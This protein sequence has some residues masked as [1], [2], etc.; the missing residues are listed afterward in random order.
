LTVATTGRR[1]SWEIRPWPS[2]PRTS[3]TAIS[4]GLRDPAGA[5]QAHP[6]DLRQVCGQGIRHRGTEDHAGPRPN[7][8]EIGNT[9]HLERIKVIDESGRMN[10]LAGP[11]QGMD[12]FECRERILEDLKEA[13]LL[14]KSSP[15]AM[16]SATAIGARP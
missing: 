3:G 6:G 13:G 8:F 10:E 9:H 4:P 7:D 14:E 1:R 11:Y 12:R 2:I 5:E 15:T 16:P